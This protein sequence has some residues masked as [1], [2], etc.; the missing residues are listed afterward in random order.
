MT[1]TPDLSPLAR[2]R[3]SPAAPG[4]ILGLFSLATALILATSDMVT[5]A[6]IAL[7]GAEDLQASLT[8]VIP[9]ELHDNDVADTRRAIQDAVEGPIDVFAAAEGTRITGVAFELT[10]YG[11]G[12]AIRVLIGIAPDGTIL[13]VR[14]LSHAE[15][16]GLGDKIELAKDDWITR[17]SGRSMT[18]PTPDR[19]KVR[20]D[21]GAFDQ[22]S[23]AT[24]TPRAVVGTVYRGLGLFD[25]HRS[26]LLAP[27]SSEDQD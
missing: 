10:G 7:R 1:D 24:I 27:L 13:G 15:T 12:G 25:R 17:F 6:P 22:F 4:L 5:K 9:A 11:Y 20:R 8:Q 21:G 14:V 18:D 2:L 26:A 19:W 23:G 16:P 3:A